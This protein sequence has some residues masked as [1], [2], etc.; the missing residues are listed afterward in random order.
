MGS[1]AFVV[2]IVQFIQGV[3]LANAVGPEEFSRVAVI[4]IVVAL[5]ATFND[6]GMS[7]VLVRSNLSIIKIK[8]ILLIPVV[9]I[10]GFSL[11][12]TFFVFNSYLAAFFVSGYILFLGLYQRYFIILQRKEL[13][14]KIALVDVVSILVSFIYFLI[15]LV[16]SNLTV[17]NYFSVFFILA[18][19][20]FI[21]IRRRNCIS[22]FDFVEFI[23]FKKSYI[24]LRS[25]DLSFYKFSIMQIIERILL[26][27]T[28]RVEQF[29]LLA[30]V[31]S[32]TFGL[33]VFAWNFVIQP[34]SKIVPVFSRVFFP[35]LV[36]SSR[37]SNKKNKD[38]VLILNRKSKLVSYP[39]LFGL[40]IFSDFMISEYMSPSWHESI[41]FLKYLALIYVIKLSFDLLNTIL[42][43]SGRSMIST[44]WVLSQMLI[45]IAFILIFWLIFESTF[46]V[47][48]GITC[49]AIFLKIIE[50]FLYSYLNLCSSFLLLKDDF[51]I[52]GIVLLS[53]SSYII[54]QPVTVLANFFTA[55]IIVFSYLIIVYFLYGFKVKT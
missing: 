13:F 50:L 11:V 18:L 3:M 42:I 37:D 41:Q 29:V 15:L 10:S 38:V 48:I 43:S 1:S 19:I 5:I 4:L 2:G 54:I 45:S 53:S 21:Y 6:F 7:N 24:V 51:Y 23:N 46:G 34:S 33:Y 12:L 52:I 20:K 31:S 44:F 26:F 22:S 36:N 16:S 25:Q 9:F 55:F 47:I 28:V 49:S 39:I 40:F 8:R 17:E 35:K 30:L 14:S 32:K 27:S